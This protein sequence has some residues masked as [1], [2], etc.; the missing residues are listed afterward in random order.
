MRLFI[1]EMLSLKKSG[2]DII[3][4]LSIFHLMMMIIKAN[5]SAAMMLFIMLYNHIRVHISLLK[6]DW[7]L[8]D[9]SYIT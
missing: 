6:N 5:T 7:V 2:K 8:R 4:P 3:S 1:K 9:H